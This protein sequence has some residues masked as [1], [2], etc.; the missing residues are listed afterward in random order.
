GEVR[1]GGRGAAGVDTDGFG[2]APA[3]KFPGGSVKG[4]ARAAE[5]AAPGKAGCAMAHID[6][7]WSA[8]TRQA[9]MEGQNTVRGQCALRSMGFEGIPIANVENACASSSTALVQAFAHIKAGLA[10]IALVV[11]AEKMFFPEKR[12]E[13]FR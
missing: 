2:K 4:L 11:G 9:M 8:N 3:G 13:T 7:A 12:E 6:A 5:T 10:E 1:S